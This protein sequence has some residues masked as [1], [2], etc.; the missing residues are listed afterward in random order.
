MFTKILED[1]RGV[2][3]VLFHEGDAGRGRPDDELLRRYRQARHAEE[4][5]RP[6]RDTPSAGVYR[7]VR[8]ELT[9]LERELGKQANS[10]T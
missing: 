1:V 5:L 4:R 3:A 7:L 8:N 2:S 9:R 6:L 10:D